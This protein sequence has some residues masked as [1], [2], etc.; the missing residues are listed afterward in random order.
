MS[1]LLQNCNFLKFKIMNKLAS[2]KQIYIY[3]KTWDMRK[4]QPPNTVEWFCEIT[5]NVKRI[6][7]AVTRFFSVPRDSRRNGQP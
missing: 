5:E 6:K 2:F 1:Y 4:Y 3:F 7:T